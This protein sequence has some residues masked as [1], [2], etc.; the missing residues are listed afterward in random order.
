MKYRNPVLLIS[1]SIL[2]VGLLVPHPES[3]S[4]EGFRCLCLF[5]TCLLLW[6]THAL[7]LAVTSLFAIIGCPLLG[8]LPPKDTYHLF[9]NGAV[10]FILGAFILSAGLM[11]TGLC[12]R[13]AL[14]FLTRFKRSPRFLL[15]GIMCSAGFMAFWIPEHAVAALLFP[16]V[17]V[18]AKALNL[19]QGKSN[20]GKALFLSLAWGSVIGGVATLLGGARN[21]LAL[22]MLREQ[23]PDPRYSIGFLGWMIKVVPIVIIMMILARVIIRLCFPSE[24]KDVTPA[25][26][27]LQEKTRELGPLSFNEIKVFAILVCAV[28]LWISVSERLGLATVS[29][30]AAV[31][32]FVVR[33]VTWEDVEDYVNWGV[34]LMYGG[35][36]TLAAALDITGTAKWLI[37]ATFGSAQFPPFLLIIL[38]TVAA[39][40][41]TEAISNVATV[42]ILL[43]LGFSLGEASGVN[44]VVIVFTVAVSSGL[45]F[46]LP[47]GT[48][49]NA[50]CFSSGYY[51]V[52]DVLKAGILLNVL[53]TLL[54]L[55][56]VKFYWGLI[57]LSLQVF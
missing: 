23:Y 9:G 47:M 2:L 10:F 43:P 27:V 28:L 42:A 12:S 32:L 52:A 3:L 16:I 31:A 44:P 7:P 37:H 17:L 8:I 22:G 24:V 14:L 11:K 45:A 34:I 30:M 54:F 50:I 1:F 15:S 29:L 39:K 56:M 21:P 19:S 18:I 40:L 33:T 26:T 38:L 5:C 25:I 36:I 49:P 41:L 51:R 20:Y 35:A 4:S 48:P 13:F 46:C 53:G 6:V 57:G 55:L